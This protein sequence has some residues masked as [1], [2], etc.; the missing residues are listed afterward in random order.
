MLIEK[1]LGA[2]IEGTLVILFGFC[3]PIFGALTARFHIG[4][5]TFLA[6][7]ELF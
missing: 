2:F 7:L 1:Y 6:L 3:L 5:L 4:A